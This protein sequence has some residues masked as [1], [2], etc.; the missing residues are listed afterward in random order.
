MSAQQLPP[1]SAPLGMGLVQFGIQP[2]RQAHNDLA[3]KQKKGLEVR[4]R[5]LMTT[6]APP[7]LPGL[8]RTWEELKATPECTWAKQMGT[9]TTLR[10]LS[11][12]PRSKAS[13]LATAGRAAS[14]PSFSPVT[15]EESMRAASMRAAETVKRITQGLDTAYCPAKKLSV[16]RPEKSV[17]PDMSILKAAPRPEREK[18]EP[19][20]THSN[21]GDFGPLV[22]TPD[23]RRDIRYMRAAGELGSYPLKSGMGNNRPMFHV[24]MPRPEG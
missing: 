5:G 24:P 1:P 23:G 19:T 9:L 13:T 12:S 22:L 4:N 20:L 6:L 11:D 16:P 8:G 10:I 21:L 7:Q 17:V 18:R 15:A 3:L 2:I 14:M